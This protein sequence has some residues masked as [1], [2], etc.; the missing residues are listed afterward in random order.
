MV[1][2]EP[3]RLFRFQVQCPRENGLRTAWVVFRSIR[4]FDLASRGSTPLP[5]L[6]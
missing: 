2:K 1:T 4:L 6:C 3:F 5:G